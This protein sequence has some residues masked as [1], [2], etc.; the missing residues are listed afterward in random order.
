MSRSTRSSFVAILFLGIALGL[1]TA[2]QAAITKTA[3]F[4][5]GEDDLDVGNNP[6]ADG[7]VPGNSLVA[8]IGTDATVGNTG[9]ATFSN[10]AAPGSTLSLMIT[11][12]GSATNRSYRAAHNLTQNSGQPTTNWGIQAWM[13]FPSTN[14]QNGGSNGNYGGYSVGFFNAQIW[15]VPNGNPNHHWMDNAFPD[16][17]ANQKDTWV[18]TAVV[19]Q[20]G[21]K[22][23]YVNGSLIGTHAG[24]ASWSGN[25][26][27]DDL[28]LGTLNNYGGDSG[29]RGGIDEASVFEFAQGEF[30]ASDLDFFAQAPGVPE[31]STF[32]LAGLGLVALGLFAWRR[33]VRG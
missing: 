28:W 26:L 19:M 33:R 22:E 18:H 8:A 23:Y 16:I 12:G 3:Q 15:Q 30:S 25:A 5:I 20:N 11:G 21:Q 14:P 9:A 1:N 4:H 17:P 27:F 13:Y 32:I 7:S 6:A 2:A 10:N 29:W 31:P 24:N